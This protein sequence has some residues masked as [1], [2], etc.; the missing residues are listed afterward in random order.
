MLNSV[1]IATWETIYMVFISSLLSITIGLALGLILFLSKDN[2]QP[3]M[4]FFSLTIGYLVNISRSIP[5]IILMILLIPFTTLLLGTSIG[6]NASIVPLAIAAIP[7]Y[8]RISESA[9]STVDRGLIEAANSMGATN[10]NIICKVLIPEARNPLISGAALTIISL[11]SYSAMAGA[12]GGGGLGSLAIQYG[13]QRFNMAVMLETVIILVILVQLVQALSD[14]LIKSKKNIIL[15]LVAVPLLIASISQII[16]TNIPNKINTIKVGVM[17]GQSIDIMQAAKK[18]AKDKYQINLEIIPFDNYDLPNEALNSGAIDANIFQHKPF[19]ESQIKNRHYKIS[20][21][22]KTYIYPMGFY[23]SKISNLQQIKRNDIVAI[24]NDPTNEGRAL[25]LLEKSGL[26]KLNKSKG[27]AVT[28]YDIT[29]N[30]YHLV[31]KEL[32]AAQ[33][34]RVLSQ[35]TIGAI[36]NDFL[37]LAKPKLTLKQ[38]LLAEDKTSPFVNLMVVRTKDLNDKQLLDI[39]SIM[40]SPKMIRETKKY[41]PNGASIPG[42]SN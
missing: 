41:Y 31:F 29:S 18:L 5:Y 8:A 34:P 17:S 22:G 21:L 16:Y 3:I 12:I 27:W 26:I 20:A 42:W 39:L 2:K 38:A 15:W 30:P 10:L 4:K 19:L 37:N 24:P 23:S 11:I 13:Y 25:L 7:F 33:I 36:T 28:P 6:T 14:H 40:H 32:D 35:V 1:L 9:I